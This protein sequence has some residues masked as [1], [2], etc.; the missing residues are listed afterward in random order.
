MGVAVTKVSRDALDW[1]L[2]ILQ[3]FGG[4]LSVNYPSWYGDLC[5][6]RFVTTEVPDDDEHPVT[7]VMRQALDGSTLTITATLVRVADDNEIGG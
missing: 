2:P 4:L 7:V 1:S 3:A 6:V 5:E